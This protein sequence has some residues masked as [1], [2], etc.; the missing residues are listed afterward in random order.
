MSLRS[1][2]AQAKLDTLRLLDI[3]GGRYEL[4]LARTRAESVDWTRFNRDFD[5]DALTAPRAITLADREARKLVHDAGADASLEV[6]EGILASGRHQ[7]LVSRVEPRLDMAC[8]LFVHSSTLGRNNGMHALRAGGIRRHD[9]SMPELEVFADTANLARAMS[10]KNAAAGLPMGGCKMSLHAE[11]VAL[12]DLD[13]LGFIGYCIEANRM[14]TGPDMGFTARHVDVLRE[15]FT[16]HC[17]GGTLGALGPTGV[18]TALGVFLAI[19]EAVRHTDGSPDLSG[20]RVAIQGLGSVGGTLAEHLAGAG[21]K[22]VVADTNPA[23]VARVQ[24]IL[25]DVEVVSPDE[26]LRV[27]CDILAPCAYGGILDEAAIDNLAC[28]MVFGGA[29]NPLLASSKDGEIRLARRL[30]ERGVLFQIEWLHN[31]AG[32]MSGF[33]EYLRGPEATQDHLRPRLER[34]CKDGTARVLALA[35]ERDLTPTE[36]A[37]QELERLLYPEA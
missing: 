2:L 17:T 9:P 32:V 35:K 15:H 16:Q 14:L 37:Y 8:H 26:I 29:N 25:R 22:L 11:P 12:D 7:L 24:S 3:G 13:R 23:A 33:E 21:A 18:P 30:H 4:T 27:P 36:V 34:V 31:T 5:T 1:T 10:Y 20:K 19:R 6:L 28:K